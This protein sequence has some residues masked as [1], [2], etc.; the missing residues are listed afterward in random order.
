MKKA[1]KV[2]LVFLLSV[3]LL[4]GGLIGLLH[5]KSV[6]TYIIGKVA[7]KISEEF[8]IDVHIGQFYFEPLSD[9]T[10]DEIYIS[11]QQKDTLAYFE[12]IYLNFDLLKLE[13]N[14]L[15]IELLT[16]KRPYLNLYTL[17]DDKLN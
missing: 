17:S 5:L 15:E 8:N 9:L 10:I 1:L 7:E 12:Q 16:I 13:E 6:Q 3:I 11:D 2:I 14:L 4:I